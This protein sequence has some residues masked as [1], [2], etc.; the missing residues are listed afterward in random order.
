[1]NCFTVPSATGLF[2]Q[3]DHRHARACIRAAATAC[4]SKAGG[5]RGAPDGILGPV[6]VGSLRA[7]TVGFRV[8]IVGG[9]IAGCAAA[10]ALSRSGH[11]VTVFERSPTRLLSRGLGIATQ[12][13]VFG[14][15]VRRDL[16][17]ADFPHRP[18]DGP[19]RW[20]VKQPAWEPL[21][22]VASAV[23][24]TAAGAVMA[25]HWGDLF[26][27]LRG[28]VPEDAYRAGALVT[29]VVPGPGGGRR[30][31]RPHPSLRPGHLR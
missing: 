1:M 20:I 2:C 7:G 23:Q 21:G 14:E 5:C 26:D 22:Y 10:V 4:A 8:G 16:I 25:M 13:G 31:R 29:A 24:S 15:L 3:G 27:T 18:Y 11:E 28:R 17:G 30:A 19:I 6:N 9:S 12:V